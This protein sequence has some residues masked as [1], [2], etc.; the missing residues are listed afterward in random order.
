MPSE[1]REKENISVLSKKVGCISLLLFF[2]SLIGRKLAFKIES[3]TRT[4]FSKKVGTSEDGG[5]AQA[6]WVSFN[7]ISSKNVK[8]QLLVQFVTSLLEIIMESGVL[9]L[10]FWRAF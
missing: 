1:N 3:G 7:R 8:V 10:D 5:P 9:Y 4:E 6:A 2:P